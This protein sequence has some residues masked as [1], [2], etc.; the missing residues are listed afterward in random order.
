MATTRPMTRVRRDPFRPGCSQR[1]SVHPS[2][3][4]DPVWRT[5]S[6][7]FILALGLT[8][9]PGSAGA[10][11][12]RIAPSISLAEL[13]TDNVNLAPSN[14]AQSDFVTQLTPSLVFSGIGARARIIGNVSAPILFFA[15]TSSENNKVYPIASVFGNVEAIDKWFFVD[16]VISVTQPF[17]S[18]FGGQPAGLTNGS[19]NRYTQETYKVSPYITGATPSDIRYELRNNSYWSNASNTSLPTNIAG[20]PITTNNSYTSEWLARVDSPVA[21]L[22]WAA[23]FDA[24]DVKFGNQGAQRMDLATLGPKYAYSP[25]LYLSLIGGYEENQFPYSSYNGGVYGGGIEWRPTERTNVVAN[26]EHRFFGTSYLVNLNHRSPLSVGAFS[27]SRGIT[28]Y[29]QQLAST[30]GTNSVAG[31]LNQLFT[32]RIPDPK[33]RQDA[34]DDFLQR[35]NLPANLSAPVNSYSE[36]VLLN[37]NVNATAGL[38]G[39]RNSVFVTAF[40]LRTE[41][42]S[43]AGNPLPS[44]LAAQNNNTQTGVNL[45]W[46]HNLTRTAVLN[47]TGFAT[48]TKANA[49]YTGETNQGGVRLDL[50]LPLSTHTTFITGAR[51]QSLGSNVTTGYTEAAVFAGLNYAFK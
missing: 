32:T 25:Q 42:I 2:K 41:P 43:G 12:W 27:A 21:P 5:H 11:T 20:I 23:R 8:F 22:G 1:P 38:L 34:V 17:F 44:G 14:A 36:Q 10:E 39:A 30:T 37:E 35:Q 49:P 19:Q 33:Q 3:P 18:P 13:A 51:Y 29:A 48:R 9:T 24:V 26:V 40:Y 45:V 31:L 4:A 7:A 47:L 50:S 16:G 46:S 15:R 6:V 28:T